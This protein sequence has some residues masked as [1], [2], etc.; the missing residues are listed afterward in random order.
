MNLHSL[1]IVG[2]NDP[3]GNA[4]RKPGLFFQRSVIHENIRAECKLFCKSEKKEHEFI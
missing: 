3:L 2:H 4:R 1:D